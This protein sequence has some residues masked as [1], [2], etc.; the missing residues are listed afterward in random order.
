MSTAANAW[1]TKGKMPRLAELDVEDHAAAGRDELRLHAVQDVRRRAVEVDA[2]EDRADDVEVRVEARAGV[3]DVE[4]HG[5][6]RVGRER[7]V[8]VLVRVAVEG[9]V[10][11]PHLARLLEVERGGRR[12]AVAREVPLARDEHEALGDLGM[13]ALGSTMIAPYMPFAMCASTGGVPQ[14]YMNAPGVSAR[15]RKCTLPPFG[16][17]LNDMFGAVSAAWKSIE[18]GIAPP[19]TS[20]TSTLSPC[21]T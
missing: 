5:V 8:L 3:D 11:G 18:C 14:W 17:V 20:V 7:V 16:I 1:L 21:R 13:P 19:F 15:K 4:A 6:A 2:V 9:H 10:V 12:L